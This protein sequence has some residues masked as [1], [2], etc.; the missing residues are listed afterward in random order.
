MKVGLMIAVMA[1][2][3]MLAGCVTQ[4][5]VTRD[6]Q[7]R[8]VGKPLNEAVK[9]LGVAEKQAADGAGTRY[10][11]NKRADQA[12][13]MPAGV[14]YSNTGGMNNSGA[15]QVD[16]QDQTVLH[17]CTLTLGVDTQG[18]VTEAAVQGDRIACSL[19]VR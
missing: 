19:F 4:T 6:V 10:E 11:W 3:A 9:Q 8:F 2:G 12:L 7:Q 13:V 16:Y 18:V 5:S 1:G 15:A 14:S 17:F